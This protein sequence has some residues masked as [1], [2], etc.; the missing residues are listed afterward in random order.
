MDSIVIMTDVIRHKFSNIPRIR[1]VN[2]NFTQLN[3]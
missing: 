2:G 1:G 3:I